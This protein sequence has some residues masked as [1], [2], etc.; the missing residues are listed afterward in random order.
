MLQNASLAKYVAQKR[1]KEEIVKLFQAEKRSL[2]LAAVV[3]ARVRCRLIFG[4]SCRWFGFAAGFLFVFAL[5]F[6][7][8]FL[9]VLHDDGNAP[10]GR[11]ERILRFAQALIGEA[12][13]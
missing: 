4:I 6:V 5:F 12:A 11:V 7:R 1:V 9:E 13:N 8:I 2:F 10:V 3:A